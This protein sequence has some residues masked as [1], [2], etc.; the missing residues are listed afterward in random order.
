MI[1]FSLA[2][3]LLQAGL[4]LSTIESGQKAG[5]IIYGTNGTITLSSD[6]V[7]AD[8]VVLDYGQNYEGHPTF[9]VFSTSGDTSGFEL[10]F[11]ESKSALEN[12]MVRTLT[13]RILVRANVMLRVMDPSALQRPWNP[14]VLTGTTFLSQASPL[15]D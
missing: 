12:Y 9:E 2:A 5:R 1:R 8:V 11:A 10:T 7:K 14:I 13:P 15:I 3:L 4:G 6:G